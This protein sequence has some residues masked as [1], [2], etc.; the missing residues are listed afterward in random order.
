M[1]FGTVS[2]SRLARF[3]RQHQL[4]ITLDNGEQVIR[5]LAV[6]RRW[7]AAGLVAGAAASL[8]ASLPRDRVSLDFFAMFAGWFAGALVAEVRLAPPPVPERRRASLRPRTYRQ[9]VNRFIWTLPPAALAASV[10]LW[11]AAPAVGGPGALLRPPLLTGVLGAAVAV[12]AVAVARRRIITRA[13]PALP[14]DRLAADEAIRSRSLHVLCASGATLALYCVL[15]QLRDLAG[16]TDPEVGGALVTLATIG[17]L[18]VPVL[19]WQVA[20]SRTVSA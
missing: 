19:G 10:A 16:L 20:M 5:Y 17:V 9:Y 2:R 11:L 4:R 3:A 6:T 1:S 13:Q 15:A 14:S 12:G 18:A 8:L 7:R